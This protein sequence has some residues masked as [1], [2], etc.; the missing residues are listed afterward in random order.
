MILYCVRHGESVYNAEG[1]IQGQID[2]ELSERG[3]RQ[4]E[5]LADTLCQTPIQAIFSSPLRRAFET[6]RPIAERLGLTIQTDERLAEIHAGIFQGL[7]WSEIETSHPEHARQWIEQLPD[8]VIPGGESRRALMIRGLA[9]FEDI[10]RQPYEHV[11]VV[12]H[13]GILSAAFKALFRVP[14]EVNPF[15]LVNCSI[16]RLRWDH[17]LKLMTLNESHHLEQVD[18][19]CGRGTGDL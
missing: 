13:G 18:G 9:V 3:R 17:K 1:R 14:A 5:A 15:E 7:R 2:I 12:A 16:S 4:S 11:A 8:F 19:G 6:A 10:R